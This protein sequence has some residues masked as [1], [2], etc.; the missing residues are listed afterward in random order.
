MQTPI[1]ELEDTGGKIERAKEDS[2]RLR[3][4]LISQLAIS[5]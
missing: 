4:G 3:S 5:K 1:K 2:K